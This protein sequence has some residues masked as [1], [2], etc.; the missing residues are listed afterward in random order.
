MSTRASGTACGAILSA[1]QI[2]DTFNAIV[3][4]RGFN[5]QCDLNYYYQDVLNRADWKNFCTPERMKNIIINIIAPIAQRKLN[6]DLSQI[7]YIGLATEKYCGD[8]AIALIIQYF[9]YK[10]EGIVKR[11][12]DLSIG[13][14]A[15]EIS[16]ED[17]GRHLATMLSIFG[18]TDK[19]MCFTA[20]ADA[21]GDQEKFFGNENNVQVNLN[22]SGRVCHC[23][24]LF[25]FSFQGAKSLSNPAN[26]YPPTRNHWFPC[27]GQHDQKNHERWYENDDHQY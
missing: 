27:G 8:T 11:V 12:I 6:L 25:F 20:P 18:L 2:I 5:P 10:N 4:N 23:V 21:P 9:D 1:N 14:N 22:C 15:N 24:N 13:Q 3:E 7:N 26:K 19:V 17:L 16:A